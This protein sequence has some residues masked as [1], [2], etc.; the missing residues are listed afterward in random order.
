MFLAH[1]D[2]DWAAV[3]TFR[4]L[5]L[6]LQDDSRQVHSLSISQCDNVEGS[7]RTYDHILVL[8]NLCFCDWGAHSIRGSLLLLKVQGVGPYPI[9]SVTHRQ[10]LEGP[11]FPLKGKRMESV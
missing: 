10:T 5:Q 7:F 8:K 9:G 1:G 3:L 4:S 2:I 11:T 6:H